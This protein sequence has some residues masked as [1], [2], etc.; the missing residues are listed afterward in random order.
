MRKLSDM[1]SVD[2]RDGVSIIFIR[3]NLGYDAAADLRQAY[4]AIQDKHVLVDLGGVTLTSSRGMA[5]LLTIILQSEDRG[6][7]VCLC[8]VSQACINI[9]D[10]AD[11]LTYVPQLKLFDTL[12]EGLEHFRRAA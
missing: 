9:L 2:Q 8:N 1:L 4:N 5:T 12:E 11:I 6:Q 10:A 7:Q 3:R